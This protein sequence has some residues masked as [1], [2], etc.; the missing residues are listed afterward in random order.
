MRSEVMDIEAHPGGKTEEKWGE[1]EHFPDLPQKNAGRR[2]ISAK[3]GRK[4]R[5]S[6]MECSLHS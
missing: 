6:R 2:P 4:W 5:Q 1:M 3:A